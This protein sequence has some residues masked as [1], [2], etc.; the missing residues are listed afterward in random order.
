[1]LFSLA[2]AASTIHHLSRACPR[3]KRVTVVPLT[4]RYAEV[5]CKHCH[6]R[7]PA[8]PAHARHPPRR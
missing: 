5:A 4:Q 8:V 7:I 6:A 3:C 2:A 1:M